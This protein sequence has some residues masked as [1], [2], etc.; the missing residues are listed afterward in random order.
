MN[1]SGGNAVL[2]GG[3]LFRS[4]LHRTSIRPA[5]RSLVSA[6]PT[7]LTIVR[8]C[9]CSGSRLAVAVRRPVVAV[10]A[11]TSQE[12]TTDCFPGEGFHHRRRCSPGACL[13]SDVVDILS[14]PAIT[15]RICTDAGHCP[16]PG[17]DRTLGL[18]PMTEGWLAYFG[19]R[20][21]AREPLT[22]PESPVHRMTECSEQLEWLAVIV[23]GRRIL[24]GKKT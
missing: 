14:M 18:A 8:L 12:Q 22:V 20:R 11:Q 10:S 3:P 19:C 9:V 1:C 2:R 15:R 23:A 13:T 24:S 21:G 5:P 6:D 7:A 17:T 4:S 16:H